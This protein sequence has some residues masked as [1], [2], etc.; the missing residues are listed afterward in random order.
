MGAGRVVGQSR[1]FGQSRSILRLNRP[2]DG[3]P[4]PNAARHAFKRSA[5]YCGAWSAAPPAGARKT[6]L[7][8]CQGH[9]QADICRAT[10]ARLL[11]RTWL[12]PVRRN[13]IKEISMTQ[14]TTESPSHQQEGEH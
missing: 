11:G 10:T 9:Y 13:L 3:P 8:E 2:G 1:C 12:F 7:E 14:V 4:S 5:P 6:R